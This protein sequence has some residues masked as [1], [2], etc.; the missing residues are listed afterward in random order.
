MNKL[1]LGGEG[2]LRRSFLPP[3][4][5]RFSPDR[6]RDDGDENLDCSTPSLRAGGSSL[7]QWSTSVIRWKITSLPYHG[8][9]AMMVSGF[10]SVMARS[11]AGDRARQAPQ[12]SSARQKLLYLVS[13]LVLTLG[14]TAG[15]AQTLA[16]DT[17]RAG[18]LVQRADSIREYSEYDSTLV[19]YKQAARLYRQH[20]Q[21]E[22]YI[23]CLNDMAHNAINGLHY[24]EGRQYAEQALV[25]SQQRLEKNSKQEAD[26]Y[27]N[28]GYYYREIGQYDS[29]LLSC[30]R[31]LRIRN[32]AK[33][34]QAKD[35][36]LELNDIGWAHSSVGNFDSALFYSRKALSLTKGVPEGKEKAIA[37]SDTYFYLGAVFCYMHQLDSALKYA[38]QVIELEKVYHANNKY[39]TACTYDF[40]GNIYG[41]K[42]NVE[43]A[44]QCH[45]ESIS[46]SKK[47]HGKK[48]ISTFYA[49]LGNS[50]LDVGFYEQSLK[51]HQHALKLKK[52][53][54]EGIASLASSHYSIGFVYFKQRRYEL[55]LPHFF[56]SSFFYKEALPTNY[57]DLS[58]AYNN[59]GDA[60]RELG[61]YDSAYLYLQKAVDI[62][63]KYYPRHPYSFVAFW[64]MAKVY[65]DEG[66]LGNAFRYYQR[67][68]QVISDAY[69]VSHY[70]ADFYNDLASFYHDGRK[71]DSALLLYEKA[72]E[73]NSFVR[74]SE[75]F[76]DFHNPGFYLQSLLGKAITLEARYH[77][78]GSQ[79]YLEQAQ[80]VCQ[81]GDQLIQQW[82]RVLTYPKDQLTLAKSGRAFYEQA[83]RLSLMGTVTEQER[84][85][86][87]RQAFYYAEQSRAGV[88][89]QTLLHNEAKQWGGVPDTLKQLEQQLH[90]DR[91]YYQSALYQA[92]NKEEEADAALVSSYENR[93]FNLNRSYDSLMQ[94]LEQQYPRYY[95]RKHAPIPASVEAIQPTLE[96]G[97][98]L[99]S[100]FVGDSSSYVFTVTPDD[101]SVQPVKVDTTLVRQF[102]TAVANS[103]FQSYPQQ[104][105]ESYFR[106]GYALYQQLVAPALPADLE[107]KKLVVVPDA[108][109]QY[110]PFDLLLTQSVPFT[111]TNLRQVPYLLRDYSVSYRYAASLPQTT[112]KDSPVTQLLIA[113]APSFSSG[114]NHLVA[115]RSADVLAPMF[116][117]WNIQEAE[118]VADG[119]SG[120]A[121][122]GEQATEAQFKAEVGDYQIVHLA[123]HAHLNDEEPEHSYL[124]LAP[125]GNEDG[126]LYAHELYNLDMAAELV[127]LSACHTG[128]GP[129]AKGEGVLSLARGFAYA[130][131][132]SVV[133]S[134]WAVD[135]ESSTQLMQT[136][137]E[138]LAEGLSKDEALRQAK[139]TFLAEAPVTNL[140]PFYWG[141][142]G[143]VGDTKSLAR[144]GE[145]LEVWWLL[146]SIIVIVMLIIR[147]RISLF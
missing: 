26:A 83:I 24:E 66:K 82:Y 39:F 33:G 122:T 31:A 64:D 18:Q 10:L 147:A 20:Q 96:P 128:D 4:L 52:E 100:Y 129:E 133:M 130:G 117:R 137:Y 143:M 89:R 107:I 3:E 51:Y 141:S 103:Q 88:L 81:Q 8:M 11:V 74:G 135:D 102:R 16:Q 111:Y 44:M 127:V 49:N 37:L 7:P 28:L 78:S 121:Y 57:W 65:Q 95:E 27:S 58:G 30:K 23:S 134:Q 13:I 72:I 75:K 106:S 42:G 19:L 98:A 115:V 9:I 92:R 80:A 40:L 109:L 140:H 84:Q 63:E 105:Y 120:S 131:C 94:V 139:L 108:A 71:Y 50:Y 118:V 86:G 146:C 70:A 55:A 21:W 116:L 36:I 67:A 114:N 104:A 85:A 126:T 79:Q 101:Y 123:T 69:E 136:F 62:V 41:R 45:K 54:G 61:G 1:T 56:Q 34:T 38:K 48:A 119:W 91:A 112:A 43:K 47:V 12:P 22:P 77:Q 17:L 97:T 32:K 59:I 124:R 144:Q 99:L 6:G 145:T 73:I 113:F 142:L 15:K 2:S 125:T 110:L 132:P 68:N 5:I 14:S 35:I 87:T 60:Y 29:V 90:I 138:K 53:R 76:I 93:L 25:E 46:L